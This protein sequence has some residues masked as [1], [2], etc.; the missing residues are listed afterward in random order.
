MK[1]VRF[2]W[3]CWLIAVW[4][5]IA[6]P[7]LAS[8]CAPAT[9]ADE[10]SSPNETQQTTEDN[11]ETTP[12]CEET[13][14]PPEI[15][16]TTTPPETEETEVLYGMTQSQ[17]DAAFADILDGIFTGK[18]AEIVTTTGIGAEFHLHFP[19]ITY[20]NGQYWAYYITYRTASGKGGVGLA[21]SDDGLNWTDHGC[22]I[23][24]DQIYDSYGTYFAGVW[25]EDGIFYLV[26]ECKGAPNTPYTLENVALA[27]SEDGIHW[28]K[29]G[30]IVKRSGT[31]W[32]KANVGTPDLYKVGDTWYVTYHGFDYVDCVVGIAYGTDLMNLK[33]VTNKPII[34]TSSGTPYSGTIG[35]RDIIYCDGYYYMVFEIS[36]DQVNGNYNGSQWSH[37]F[38]RSTDM[39]S[40]ELC[41]GP[42]IT[43]ATAGM[44]YDGPCWMVVD[45]ELYVYVRDRDNSTTAIKLVPKA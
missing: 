44:G 27:V 36:T 40:W 21:V 24:P 23:Q 11:Q 28:Q 33:V 34:K 13:T 10:E 29:K 38:A 45:N 7:C 15:E 14:I 18:T 12:D 6:L 25:L 30:I 1:R 19:D 35:R 8:S 9:D 17:V 41:S 2:T 31:G 39:F 5:L 3:I 22:V 32:Q 37:M 20:H 42:L 43:Q 4:I 16:E 26:Y